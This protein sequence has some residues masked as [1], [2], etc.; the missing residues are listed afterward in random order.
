MIRYYADLGERMWKVVWSRLSP[1]PITR[2]KAIEIR[3]ELYE[4]ARRI[5]TWEAHFDFSDDDDD[6]DD[7]EDKKE[8]RG[9]R[10][11]RPERENRM[12]YSGED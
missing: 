10:S 4:L 3:K 2:Q 1:S 6:D 8:E 5:E 11:G 7:V 12:S 9:K